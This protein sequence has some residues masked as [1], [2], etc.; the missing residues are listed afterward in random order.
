MRIAFL[1]HGPTEWNALGRIQ[2]HTDI[3][4][5][6]AGEAKMAALRLPDSITPSRVFVSP[7][8]RARQTA[9]LLGLPDDRTDARLMEQHW[10]QWEGLSRAEILA[11]HGE[12][13]FA[14][15]GSARAF[16]PLGGESTAELHDRVAHFL[17]DVAGGDGDA[18]V[19]AHLGVLRAAYTLATGWDMAT[20][21]PPDLDV[22]RILL[23][24]L[25][26]DGTPG[27]AALNLE[28]RSR[29][30]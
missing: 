22:S 19:V 18:V 2:G 8:M 12:D 23:L 6:A 7:L 17:R 5:S 30:A 13:A 27:I 21:M 28:F 16:R 26:R 3:P 10:G 14:R 9:R 25:A 29:T 20:P 11:R 24:S 1:R 15:A 4:L